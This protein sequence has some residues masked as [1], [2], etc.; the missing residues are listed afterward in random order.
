[1][2]LIFKIYSKFIHC[3][4]G[5]LALSLI[6]KTFPD[7]RSYLFRQDQLDSGNITLSPLPRFFSSLA[8]MTDFDFEGHLVG[9]SIR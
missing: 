9:I 3:I 5:S 6:V 8:P 7:A 4:Q 2:T 1:M